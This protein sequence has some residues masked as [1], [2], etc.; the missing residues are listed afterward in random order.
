MHWSLLF[1]GLSQFLESEEVT[2]AV[3]PYGQT[4]LGAMDLAWDEYGIEGVSTQLLYIATNLR[5]GNKSVAEQLKG[6]SVIVSSKE[7]K[8]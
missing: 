1:P 2:S 6:W 4:Y 5:R 7:V 3:D 8:N